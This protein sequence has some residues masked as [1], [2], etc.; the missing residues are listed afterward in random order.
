MSQPTSQV[1]AKDAKRAV[2]NVSALIVASIFS[3]GVLFLWQIVVGAWLGPADYGIYGTILGLLA[4]GASIAGFG[5]G[6]IAIREVAA[7][8]DQIGDYAAAMLV[9][10][11]VTS[12][13]AYVGVVLAALAAGYS[14]IIVAYTAIA[15]IS[16][17]IDAGGNIAH[18]L[19]LAQERMV[20]TS[21][22]DIVNILLRVMLSAIVV[23]SGGGLLGLY[24]VTI[25][26]GLLRL[27][28]F[29]GVQWRNGLRLVWPVKRG[30][31]VPM[32][33][34]ATPLALSA[35]LFLAYQHADKLMVTAIIGEVQT[36]YITPAFTINF[37]VTEV[38]ST[39]V[40]IAMYPLLTRY[41]NSDTPQT[42]GFLVEKLVRFMLIIVLPV[43]LVLSIYADA[44]VAFIFRS[45]EFA[46]TG[47]I[48]RILIWYTLL[49]SLTSVFNQALLIQNRQR[50]TLRIRGTSL[51]LNI[52]LNFI[53]LLSFRDPRG[54][55]LASVGAEALALL[56]M[57]RVF[58]TEGFSL[59][60]LLPRSGRVLLVGALAGS[61]ML[62][63]DPALA[64]PGIVT[65]ALVY[66]VGLV[67]G[68]V[69]GADDWDLLY[70]LL[71]ALPGG[72][73]VQ[74]YWRREVTIHW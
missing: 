69:L 38:L 47:G 66:T 33:V 12:G 14:E 74:R 65:G 67:F 27:S 10:Q 61:V 42:F 52:T 4:I 18:D 62:L 68:G 45:G 26:T 54:A 9:A 21:G 28:L 58:H 20:V 22:I 15:G 40:M 29:W 53:L 71:V 36:G 2:R 72:H 25:G 23:A 73:L 51:L 48:L 49:S 55:A 32:L 5:I 19:L 37:G 64:L 16:L 6:M 59:G 41:F 57:T 31:L 43:A 13:L 39:T 8:P 60:R 11:T 17:L 35:V 7:H 1:S 44:I 50:I 63:I 46:P 34:N 70:R 3:K 56:L 24:L 30:V